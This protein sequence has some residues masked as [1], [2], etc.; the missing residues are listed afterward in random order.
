MHTLAIIKRSL[1]LAL[2]LCLCVS[3]AA[4]A[5]QQPG[6]VRGTVKDEFGGLLVGA[7]VTLVDA[8]GVP[9]SV[10]TNEEGVYAINALAPG[11]YTVRAAAQGFAPFE[12]IN[13]EIVA[14][15]RAALDIQLS[16]TL[17][18]EEV[19][20]AG[21]TPISTDAENNSSSLVIKGTDLDAL[22]DDPDDLAAAL[23]ALAGPAAGRTV[24]RFLLTASQADAFRLKSRSARFASI[25]I[26]SRPS[27]I[28]SASGA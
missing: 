11:A 19:I 9:K 22:P 7:T 2:A 16:V 10:Q 15:K 25:K 4:V 17:A 20:V 21:E 3:V 28:G 14:G 5:Q 1:G 12:T 8:A 26:R 18:R 23:Q 6:S 24:D 13:F 27:L